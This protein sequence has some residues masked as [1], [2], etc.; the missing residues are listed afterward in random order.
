RILQVMVFL[1]FPGVL[2]LAALAEPLFLTLFPSRWLDAVPYLQ[3]MCIAAVM[4]PL[5]VLNLN[6][7]QVKGRSDLFL[8]LE[9][10]KK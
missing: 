10:V 6:V 1:L 9:I 5:S 8:G 7:L 3:L 4:H 2:L